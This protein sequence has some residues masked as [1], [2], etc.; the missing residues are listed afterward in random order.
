LLTLKNRSKAIGSCSHAVSAHSPN[1]LDMRIECC[2]EV[3]V[4]E[5]WRG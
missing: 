3:G 1:R 4:D 5:P 2:V